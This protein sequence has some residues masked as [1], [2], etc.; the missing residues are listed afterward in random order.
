VVYNVVM[1]AAA[2]LSKL[3]DRSSEIGALMARPRDWSDTSHMDPLR[4][5][6]D[7]EVQVGA[8]V[9]YEKRSSSKKKI[10]PSIAAKLPAPFNSLVFRQTAG[11]KASGGGLAAADVD[12]LRSGDVVMVRDVYKD[13]APSKVVKDGGG[14]AAAGETV[15]VDRGEVGDFSWPEAVV[16]EVKVSKDL[17]KAKDPKGYSVVMKHSYRRYIVTSASGTSAKKGEASVIEASA[18]PLCAATVVEVLPV[19]WDLQYGRTKVP[20][21]AIAEARLQVRNTT[22]A[23]KLGQLQPSIAVFPQECMANLH[24]FG[25]T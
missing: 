4:L 25:P 20:E 3:G 19:S 8:S 13:L 21:T 2:V 16:I 24:L 12:S 5:S 18:A 10:N 23:Q 9:L 7:T 15:R 17:K 1:D 11:G 6:P 22:L 14:T